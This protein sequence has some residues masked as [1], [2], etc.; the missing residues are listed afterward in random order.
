MPF[1]RGLLL[2]NS[3]FAFDKP[4]IFFSENRNFFNE[5]Y[6]FFDKKQNE[7]IL[8]LINELTFN[9]DKFMKSISNK[10]EYINFIK[11]IELFSK[12]LFSELKLYNLDSAHKIIHN[13]I[14]K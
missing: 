6:F 8:L 13:I 9:G 7:K 1:L 2:K 10:S 4:I 3:R 11:K 12:K 14:N 5:A